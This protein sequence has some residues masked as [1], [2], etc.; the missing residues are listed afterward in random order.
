MPVGE[1]TGDPVASLFMGVVRRRTMRKLR[2]LIVED[3]RLMAAH[4]NAQLESLG[5][6]VVGLVKD[7]REAVKSALELQPDLIIMDIRTPGMDGID[8]A[9][10]I[11]GHTP[12]PIIFLTAYAAAD[13]VRQARE[14]GVMAYLVRRVDKRQLHS[15]IEMAQPGGAGQRSPDEAAEAVRGGGLPT[16]AAT[17]PEHGKEP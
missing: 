14:A 12:I 15:T 2:V 10:T 17:A 6:H 1:A 9:R 16:H 5:H 7:R 8:T 3:K 4:L 13:F 11:M